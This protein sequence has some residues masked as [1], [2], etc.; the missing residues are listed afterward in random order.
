MFCVLFFGFL[1]RGL[2][3]VFVFVFCM[4]GV[5]TLGHPLEMSL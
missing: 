2:F 1:G 4:C 5:R 3:L